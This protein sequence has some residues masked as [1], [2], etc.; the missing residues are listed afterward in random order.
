MQLQEEFGERVEFLGV[1]WEGFQGSETGS[2]LVQTVERVS[3]EH[4]VTW[5]SL[6]VGVEPEALF[7][8]LQ[9]QCHTIPQTW[10]VNSSGEVVHRV[11]EVLDE[12]S[13]VDLKARIADLT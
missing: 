8:A 13:L 3:Q 12:A 7:E 5:K 10:L 9:M 1:S 4:G 11:E 2:A 6:I